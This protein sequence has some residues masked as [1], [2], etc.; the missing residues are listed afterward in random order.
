MQQATRPWQATVQARLI[1]GVG[2]DVVEEI[3]T[4]GEG[5]FTRRVGVVGGPGP[6]P[7]VILTQPQ[8][9]ALMSEL[10]DELASAPIGVDLAAIR[11]FI[12]LIADALAEGPPSHRFDNVRFGSVTKDETRGIL[13][14]HVVLG[15]D[16]I[17]TVRDD[18]QSFSYEQQVVVLPAGAYSP[19]SLPDIASLVQALTRNRPADPLWGEIE[20]DAEAAVAV[21]A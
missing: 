2:V 17:G 4:D 20:R 12:D 21:A 16:V 3:A 10:E 19:L 8:L 5:H 7:I 13:Y 9:R 18:H 1:R 14:G 15:V 11:A 6:G